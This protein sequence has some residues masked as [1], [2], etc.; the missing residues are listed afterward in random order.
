MGIDKAE[1]FTLKIW[2]YMF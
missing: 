2:V 1:N